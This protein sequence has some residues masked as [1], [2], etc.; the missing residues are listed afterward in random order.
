MLILRLF[1]ILVLI[2]IVVTFA[3][4]MLSKDKRYI[5]WCWQII[6]F[7]L[8]LLLLAGTVFAIGRIILF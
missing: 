8:V 1:A 3:M 2:A 7:S 4:Y 6:K 5:A